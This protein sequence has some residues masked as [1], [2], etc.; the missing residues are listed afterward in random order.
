MIFLNKTTTKFFLMNLKFSK[1]D[2]SNFAVSGPER[3]LNSGLGT[4][5]LFCVQ[6]ATANALY[7]VF[8]SLNI[9][10]AKILSRVIQVTRS[11]KLCS[12]SL[13]H[14]YKTFIL[15]TGAQ[16]TLEELYCFLNYYYTTFIQN[17]AAQNTLEE[18]YCF[19]NYCYKTFILNTGAQNTLEELYYSL[20]HYYM[21]FVL[22]TDYIK[23]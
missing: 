22:Y 4:I 13:N 17:T 3:S 16:N 6:I 23:I 21:T 12:S 5:F 19:L 8:F 14:Y 9:K 11:I 7:I 20:N 10:I 15:N 2:C 18:L 1:L